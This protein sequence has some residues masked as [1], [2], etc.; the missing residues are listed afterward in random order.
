MQKNSKKAIM[1]IELKV[2]VEKMPDGKIRATLNP[3][4]GICVV[5]ADSVDEIEDRVN[6]F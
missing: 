5:D 2:D 6:N 3:G 4:G 1:I